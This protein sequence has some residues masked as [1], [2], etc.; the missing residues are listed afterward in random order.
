MLSTS[1]DPV[2]PGF[3]RT[4]YA[5]LVAQAGQ[6]DFLVQRTVNRYGHCPELTPVEI[7]KA[8][9]DLVAWVELGVKPTP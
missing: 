7:A 1:R 5:N 4:A 2:V 9:G 3:H 8:L 6:S